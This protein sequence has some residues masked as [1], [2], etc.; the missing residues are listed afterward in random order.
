MDTKPRARPTKKQL[1]GLSQEEQQ[2]LISRYRREYQRWWR[3]ERDKDPKLE[4]LDKAMNLVRYHRK[5]KDPEGYQKIQKARKKS[6]DKRRGTRVEL[7]R[8]PENSRANHLRSKFQID[9]ELYLKLLNEQNG[10]CAICF[11]K[12]KYI[13]TG[14]KVMRLSVDHDHTTGKIRGLLCNSCN[15][16]LGFLLDDP[17]VTNSATKYLIEH[18]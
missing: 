7:P 17:E 15:R 9:N 6:E 8:K 18:K 12:E 2:E 3:E 11:K 1:E 14:G 13:G 4:A 16:A 10:L 5:K